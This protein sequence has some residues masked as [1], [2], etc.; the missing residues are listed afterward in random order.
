MSPVH[1]GLG[2]LI[3]PKE[4]AAQSPWMGD[5]EI[6]EEEYPYILPEEIGH[7]KALYWGRV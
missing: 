1:S 7:A 4:K 6:E 3:A 5:K 2:R